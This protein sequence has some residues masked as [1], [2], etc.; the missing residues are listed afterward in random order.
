[1]P[2]KA[3]A[4][5]KKKAVEDKTFGLKNKNKSS[6]VS[7]YVEQVKQQVEQGGNPRLKKEAEDRKVS[8]AQK[9]A[10]EEAKKAELAELFKPVQQMQKVPFGVDPKTIVCQYFKA[11]TCQKGSKC[12][13]SHNLDLDRK[14]TKI[15]IYADNEKDN[16]AADTMDKWDDAKLAEVVGSKQDASNTN[17]P[18]EIVC[19]FFLDAIDNQ[20]YG[21]FWECPNGNKSCKYR[22]ALP[23]G[24]VL[25]KKET[26]A[27]R[28]E[29]EAHEKENAITIEDFLDTER[30]NLG[31]NLTPINEDTF[32]K[33]KADR[34]AKQAEEEDKKAKDKAEAFKK[35]RSGMKSGMAFSGKELFDFNPDWAVAGD[36]DDDGAM[37]IYEREDSDHED[38]N[39]EPKK[40]YLGEDGG[41][42]DDLLADK[43]KGKAVVTEEFF[44]DLEG[45][46]DDEEN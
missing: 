37:D 20:K 36:E 31:P 38:E 24:Y 16:K 11:G 2:P 14:V 28:R 45:L 21:W 10:A 3:Q 6:K 25:K 44:D 35:L 8:A 15:D 40:A 12:K 17:L 22:H 13:F 46:D 42:V 26:E 30:H 7:K 32:H 23:P 19:K 41:K 43:G 5:A 34:K 9:K 1:M 39:N 33:W 4:A 29:R 18:T 27:E